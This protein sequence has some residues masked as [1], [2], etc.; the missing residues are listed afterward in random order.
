MGKIRVLVVDDS[1]VV[2]K[3]L[4]ALINAEPD[5]E[6]VATAPDPYVARDKLVQLK[7]D[8]MT[9]DIEMP[10]MDGLTFLGKVM[11]YF[12]TPTIIVSSVTKR[13]CVVSLQ[14]LEMGA[15]EVI[16]KPS[17]AYSIEAI[18]PFLL[19][20]IRSAAQAR[21]RKPTGTPSPPPSVE[22]K[23]VTTN[24]I[25]A[26]GAST[27]GTEAI[28]DVLT[29]LP[30]NA[31]GTVI[32]QHMPPGFTA[33]FAER[34]N[35]LSAM[36][37]REARDGESLTSGLALVAPGNYHLSLRRDGARYFVRV[38]NGPRVWRQ[39]PSVDVLFKSVAEHAAG[40][41]VG[42]LLTGMGR[43]GAEGLKTMHDAGAR[44]IC[45]DEATCVVYG[46]PKVG[47]E[48]GAADFV[49]PIHL[50]AERVLAIL[51]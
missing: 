7:P 51:R 44:T 38:K 49:E 22:L 11:H 45:Q 27:G 48:L 4:V 24:K 12:P 40:N 31:P 32:A 19:Q 30:K 5:L 8:V 21:L 39:R 29:R 26:I 15:V 2:R 10:R 36:E 9:L 20:A 17:E 33:S 3:T 46:M 41:S 47:I 23:I 43:D 28:K 13:G 16:P 1:A 14:A 50:V 6:V 42:V 18:E 34:L 25:L 35:S 37:V